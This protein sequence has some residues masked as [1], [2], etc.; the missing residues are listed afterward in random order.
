M[1]GSSYGSFDWSL[2]CLFI[3]PDKFLFALYDRK[4]S[5][6]KGWRFHKTAPA[7]VGWPVNRRL[8]ETFLQPNNARMTDASASR[9]NNGVTDITYIDVK[10]F[11]GISSVHPA[12]GSRIFGEFILNSQT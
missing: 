3:Q 1:R 2:P 5:H 12:I 7:D 10:C 4:G 8:P 11:R 6:L 9:T